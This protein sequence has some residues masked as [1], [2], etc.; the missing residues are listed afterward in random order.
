MLGLFE[1]IY[2]RLVLRGWTPELKS[3]GKIPGLD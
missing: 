3:P 2:N 1:A